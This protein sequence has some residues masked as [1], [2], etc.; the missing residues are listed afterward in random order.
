VRCGILPNPILL[1]KE[2]R[3]HAP[4]VH[5]PGRTDGYFN[6]V[7][8]LEQRR[9]A[10][11]IILAKARQLGWS[12]IT[13]GLLLHKVIFTYGI[14]CIMA[15]ADRE[16]TGDMAQK[17]FLGYDSLPWWLRPVSSRRVESQQGMLMFGPQRSGIKFQH[18]AQTSGIARGSTIVGYHLA[19]AASYSNAS[20]IVEASLFKAVHPSPKVFGVLEST[21]EG[22]TGWWHDTYWWS[23]NQWNNRKAR[24][25]ALFLPFYLGTDMYPNETWIRTRPVPD[26]W[27]PEPETRSMMARAKLYVQSNPV[28]EKVLGSTWN[29]TTEVAWYWEVNWLEHRAKGKEKLWFQEMPTDDKEAFQGSYDSVFGREVIAEVYTKRKQDYDCYGVVGQS[30]EDKH[31]P[32]QED[33]DYDQNRILVKYQDRKGSP[34]M[35][36]ELVPLKWEEPWGE[37]SEIRDYDGHD[38]KLF[39]W[40]HPSPDCDYSIG[41]DTSNGIGEDYTVIA[42]ARRARGPAEPDVQVAEFRSRNVSHVEAWPFA[43]AIAAYYSRH[44]PNSVTMHTEP[45]VSVE[46]VAAVGDTCQLQMFHHMTRYDSNP[47]DMKKSKSRKRGWF[48]HSWSRPILLDGFVIAVQNGWYV[49]QSPWT[50]WEMDHWEVHYTA[51]GKERKEH[52]EDSKDDGIFANAMATF[53]PNDLESLA[54]RSKK[55][56]TDGV[57]SPVEI[58]ITPIGGHKFSTRGYGTLEKP[59]RDYEL[60]RLLG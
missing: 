55:R 2:P 35:R 56:S 20:E 10:V 33:V 12:T 46:Q 42:V 21:C 13:A 23:K 44:M 14:D 50:I 58:D 38:C 28:L 19:E 49:I 37:L 11:E 47:K 32:D 34:A 39:I 41:I 6:V 45:Y 25:M 53:C 22:D 52:S 59:T 31:E 27:R 43:L 54:K 30:I 9:A 17:I 57:D 7:S 24:L 48:T 15:S 16:K 5:I 26:D 40:E 36:W 8:E 60:E 4:A 29:M 18:G 1:D 51:T 3:E